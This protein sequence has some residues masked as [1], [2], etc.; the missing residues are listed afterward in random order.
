LNRM[1]VRFEPE[2]SLDRPFGQI[3][4]TRMGLND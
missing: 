4:F 2:P 3:A 1:A